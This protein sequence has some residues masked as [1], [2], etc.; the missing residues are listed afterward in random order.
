[1]SEIIIHSLEDIKRAAS[2]FVAL[3]GNRRIFAFY[4]H[5]G[6]GKTTFIKAICEELGVTDAV[7]SPTFAIVNEYASNMGSIYHFDFYRIK[8]SSEVLDLG[9]E[10]YAYS[11][12][13]CLME[14]P[15]LIEE[16]LPEETIDVHIEEIEGGKR[17]VMV[18]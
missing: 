11:G 1:M 6:A 5:M 12:N 4:G 15:E 3:I 9:F 14:W 8:R 13:L 10:D 2:E 16:F 17:R 7:S 18:G